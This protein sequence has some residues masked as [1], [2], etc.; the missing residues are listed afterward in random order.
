MWVAIHD[1]VREDTIWR[2]RW[3][4]PI[5]GECLSEIAGRGGRWPSRLRGGNHPAA[6]S[7]M[8]SRN[9]GVSW[10]SVHT[11]FKRFTV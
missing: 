2:Q 5:C 7:P 3:G 4:R 11:I 10:R 8:H 1:C 9:A 6:P